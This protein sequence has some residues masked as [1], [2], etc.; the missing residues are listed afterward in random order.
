MGAGHL[1]IPERY[2]EQAEDPGTEATL[3]ERLPAKLRRVADNRLVGLANEAYGY[4][5]HPSVS[6]RHKLLGAAALLYFIAPMDAVADWVPGLGY[7][8]DV[9][10]LTAFVMSMREA[11]KEVVAHT[12]QA[13]SEVVSQAISES[14]DAWARRGISQVCLSLW[15]TTIAACIGLLYSG[16]RASVFEGSAADPLHDPFFWGCML[17]GTFGLV[18][19]VIFAVRLWRRYAGARAEIKE[20]LAYAIVSLADWR[21]IVLLALPVLALGV[22]LVLRGASLLGG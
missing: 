20:P 3:R 9:A 8:D 16:T 6:K 19:H 7:V 12:R 1:P 2:V 18:T 14:R 11:A 17:A 22:V 21:Q 15:A 5:T 10:V 4:A 13:A